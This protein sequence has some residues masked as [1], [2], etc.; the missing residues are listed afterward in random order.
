[1]QI[2]RVLLVLAVLVS[3]TMAEFHRFC[4]DHGDCNHVDKRH[5]AECCIPG[6]MNGYHE[7]LANPNPGKQCPSLPTFASPKPKF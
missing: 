5:P 4:G 2:I 1:M 7:C 6:K 3:A